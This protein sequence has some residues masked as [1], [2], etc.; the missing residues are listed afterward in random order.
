MVEQGR[1]DGVGLGCC[2]TL[3][4]DNPQRLARFYTALVGGQSAAVGPAVPGGAVT[5]R[6]PTG[7]DVVLYRPSRQHPQPRR[8]A[9]QN[10]GLAFCLRCTHLERARQRAMELGARVVEP[11]R[12]ESF[13]REQ[14]LLDPE[15][16]PVLL[17]ATPMG[18][19][20]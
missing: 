7:M 5:V 11:V 15:G 20:V 1:G 14:W 13:G 18:H 2:L 10:S 17:W 19:P 8:N 6:L 3:A 12:E 9:R 16:N 4:S